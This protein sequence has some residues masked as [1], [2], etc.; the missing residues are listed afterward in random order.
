MARSDPVDGRR[1]C[2]DAVVVLGKLLRHAQA[3]APPVEQPF[4]YEYFGEP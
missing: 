4:Q 2:Q 1:A 3:L